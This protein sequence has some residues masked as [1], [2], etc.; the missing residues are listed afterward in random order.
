MEFVQMYMIGVKCPGLK[1]WVDSYR[2]PR[3][4]RSVQ[5]VQEH[6]VSYSRALH[7]DYLVF[8]Q[9]QQLP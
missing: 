8:N 6:A 5:M 9:T 3:L 7:R 2:V 1:Q 4:L